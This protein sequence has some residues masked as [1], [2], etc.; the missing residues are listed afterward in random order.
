MNY[1][2]SQLPRQHLQFSA[3]QQVL[4]RQEELPRAEQ[5]R[6][7]PQAGLREAGGDHPIEGDGTKY[8]QSPVRF[9]S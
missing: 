1:R 7:V 4:P 2:F 5:G 8:L 6:P 9:T 3:A